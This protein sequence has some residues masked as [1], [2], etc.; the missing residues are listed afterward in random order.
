VS[1]DPATP[2]WVLDIAQKQVTAGE[3]AVIDWMLDHDE[4]PTDDTLW[5]H[6]KLQFLSLLSAEATKRTRRPQAAG[7]EEGNR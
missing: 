6:R 1:P 4:D 3:Q 5:R 7:T 2:A